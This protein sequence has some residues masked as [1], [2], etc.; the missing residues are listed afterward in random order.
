VFRHIAIAT[1]I[2]AAANPA[3]LPAKVN[4]KTRFESLGGRNEVALREGRIWLR[5]R[6]SQAN[7][8]QLP[9]DG[10]PSGDKKFQ[11]PRSISEISAD[12]DNL[13]AVSESGGVYYMKFSTSKWIFDDWGPTLFTGV[14]RVDFPHRSI[15]ISHRGPEAAYYE[16]IDGNQFPISQGVSTLYALSEDGRRILYADPWLPPKWDHVIC[17]PLR[18]RFTA[19]ALDASASTLFVADRTGRMFTRLAD[20]DSL[21]DDPFLS[22]TY[23]RGF[24]K[25][26]QTRTLPP[27]DWREQP[28]IPGKM[29]TRISILQTGKGNASRELRVQG[30]DA[31][32]V[33][34]YWSKGIFE[35]SWTFVSTGD[36]VADTDLIDTGGSTRV[37][38]SESALGPVLDR[39]YVG[40]LRSGLAPAS[41]KVELLGYQ[42]DCSPATLRWSMG[43]ESTDTTLHTRSGLRTSDH[44]TFKGT[45]LWTPK[46]GT[47]LT[48]ALTRTL[49]DSKE[50]EFDV[51]VEGERVRVSRRLAYGQPSDA[52]ILFQP[53]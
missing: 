44:R 38:A 26:A 48:K 49:G 40:E 46:A 39:N 9:P 30:V 52:T 13:I 11:R 47:K 15:A 35:A 36:P 4:L 37:G 19:E 5:N 12:G 41:L 6:G 27:E 10:L 7:W 14:L 53:Y 29:T 1:T 25:G 3:N 21:G 32:G 23:E 18:G 28:P 45:A 42:P 20:F 51:V 22:Y 50:I 2:L 16:D 33:G 17:P 43:D 24:R 34:G 8:T 31:K